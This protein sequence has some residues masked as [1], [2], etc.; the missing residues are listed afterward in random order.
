MNNVVVMGLLEYIYIYGFKLKHDNIL[1]NLLNF[2]CGFQTKILL[3]ES[4]FFLLNELKF[5]HAF[6][7]PFLK[8]FK[9]PNH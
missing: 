9:E 4:A 7:L 6:F 3:N 1:Y 2:H 8:N 5:Y